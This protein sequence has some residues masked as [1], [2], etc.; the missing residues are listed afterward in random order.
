MSFAADT[1]AMP[2]PIS[3]APNTPTVSTRFGGWPNTF[4]FAAVWP[5]K[6]PRSAADSDEA[7]SSPKRR[8]ST[9]DPLEWPP[10][11]PALTHSMMLSG[12]GIFP[13]VAFITCSFALSNITF[14]PSGFPSSSVSIHPFFRCF[15]FAFPAARSSAVATA[16][17][18]SAF[19]ST[20]RSTSPIFLARA[21]LIIFPVSI[22]SSAGA[23]P[24][25]FGSRC[26]PPAPGRRPSI[27]SGSP[28]VVFDDAVAT[29]C[30]HASATSRP[31]PRQGP[32]I[33]ATHGF[34]FCIEAI[35]SIAPCP[36][37]D[38]SPA[39]DASFLPSSST[40]LMLAPAMNEPCL[41]E[42]STTAFTFGSVST[43]FTTTSISSISSRDSVFCF[44]PWQ[45]SRSIA[46]PLSVTS[47]LTCCSDAVERLRD[48]PRRGARRAPRVRASIFAPRKTR[49]RS[50]RVHDERRGALMTRLGTRYARSRYLLAA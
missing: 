42:M 27:T 2:A 18:S 4:F 5:K 21:A 24:T 34:V 29:R 3:P 26:V 20:T 19:A 15:A 17:R 13:F 10:S 22:M 14:R 48:A 16:E 45:S 35:L 33:A 40:I 38:A 49:V 37:A 11:R 6:R 43:C 32:S 39:A 44:S 30:E 12:A 25:S 46:T 28:S 7:A 36:S 31:P 1:S 47:S 9:F 8:A 41:S 23:A 50:A